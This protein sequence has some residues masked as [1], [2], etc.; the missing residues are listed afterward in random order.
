[1]IERNVRSRPA[2]EVVGGLLERGVDLL[3]SGHEDEDRVGEADHDV[4]DHHGQD[5][6]RDPE[7]MEQQEQRDPEHDVRDHERAQQ[8]RRGRRFTS[9]LAPHERDRGDDPECNRADAR[10][11][12]DD[13]TRLQRRPQVGVDD[14]VV[15]PVERE[16]AERERRH[17]RVVEREDEQDDDRR[18]QE[19]DDECEEHSQGSCPELRERDVHQ[20]AATR[21]GWR[22]REKANVKTVT[23]PSR[24]SASTEPV[25]QSGKPVPNRSTIW[26][27][28]M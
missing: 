9:E 7:L 11:R 25:C 28:Y 1:M 2:P 14:E 22:N 27:P 17:L 8:E 10:E 24:K 12:R 5:R 3:Q 13:R 18:V 4:A 26:L 16:P 23:T 20:S 19:D 21:R 15:V 6:A